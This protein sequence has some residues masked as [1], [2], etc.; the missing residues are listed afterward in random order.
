MLLA[1]LRDMQWRRR[2]FAIA[3]LST[4]I[5]FGMT[6]VLTGLANGFQTEAER[7]VDSLGVD[8]FV[9]KAGASGPFVGATP[10]APVELRRIAAAPGVEAAAPLAYAGGT[11]TLD[12]ETR[13]VDIFGAPERGPGMP[14]VTEGRPPRDPDEVAVSTTLGRGV[15]DE[16]EIASRTLRI[17]G[18][19]EN[20]TALA[21]L[22]NVFLTTQG[23]QRLIYG[24]E[25][26]VASIG[27]RGSLERV[28][29]G[30]RA[31]DRAGAIE[32]LLRPLKV[33]VNS[34]TIV[35]VLLWIVAALIVGSVV[36]LSVLERL[37]DFAVFKAIG[38]P[39]RSVMAGLALQAVIV[40]L[41]AAL[42]GAGLSLLLGPLF[43]MQVIVPTQAFVALPI[44]AVV[45]GLIASAAGLHRAVAV[46]PALA[47]GGP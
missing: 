40:A 41:L 18:L 16:V 6:L 35:A 28:P 29:D 31:V 34:I 3:V 23:A 22:P 39:T 12:G 15:G 13:N 37:R 25:P 19:V 26:L 4:A 42:V 14:A 36:Y 9:V 10:F 21:N 44:V 11:A 8:Q 7:T 20:S 45:I 46:D 38:V 1:A 27:V 47:F 17:V 5:I 33:A 2:R 24:G 32:D 30:Y 43:P